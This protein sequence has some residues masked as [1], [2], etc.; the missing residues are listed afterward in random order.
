MRAFVLAL[1]LLLGA[2]AALAQ[3]G[4][5]TPSSLP[6]EDRAAIRS[7]IEKQIDAFRRDD[8][9]AAF[10]YASPGI[11]MQFGDAATFGAMVRRGYQPV[12]HPRRVQ[13]GGL[14]E[15]EGR[16]VQKVEV[17]GPDGVPALAL[18]FMEREADGAW[19]IDG[20]VLAPAAAEGA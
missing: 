6:A 7:V 15:G 2:S 1:W 19:R 18:Y 4:G 13:F 11:Q 17:I 9:A 14:V 20:C 5:E 10:A 12:Y 8:D 3:S 16:I